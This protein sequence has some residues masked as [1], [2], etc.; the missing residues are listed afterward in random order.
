MPVYTIKIRTK[1]ETRD[2]VVRFQPFNYDELG[3]TIHFMN[4]H[5]FDEFQSLLPKL[6]YFENEEYKDSDYERVYEA[7]QKKY[8]YQI[9][10][11]DRNILIFDK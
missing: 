2:V 4:D 3:Y 7:I 6:D 11:S 1:E 10:K 9:N 8:G 5:F